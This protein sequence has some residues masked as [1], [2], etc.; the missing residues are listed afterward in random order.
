MIGTPEYMSPEQVEGKEVDQRSDIYSLGVILYEMVTGQVPFEGDTPFAIGVRHKSEIPRDPKELNAQIP[1][2]LSN[3]I[4][5]CLEKDKEKRYQS[6]GEV[7]S[8]LASI[9]KG[10]P[11]TEKIIPEKKPI[12]SREITVT[13]GIKKLFIPA[14]VVVA[15]IIIAILIWQPWS[16]REAIPGPSDKPSLAVMYFENNTGDK[17][18]DH[19][20]KALSELLIADLS[21]SKF[22]R[23]LSGDRLFDILEEMNLLEEDSYSSK[24]LENVAARGGVENILRGGYSKAGDVLRINTMLQKI[25]TGELLSS[26]KVEG[27]GEEGMFSMVDELTRKIKEDFKLSEEQIASDKDKEV[28]KITT[29]FPEAYKYY[30]EGRKYT[31][32]GDYRQSISF[33]ERAVA[34][35]PEFAMAYRSMAACYSNLGR[36][37]EAKKYWQKALELSDRLSEKEQLIIHGDFFY[38]VEI[39]YDRAIEFYNK[40]LSLYPDNII[41]N[42]NLGNIYFRLE[43]WDKAK[44]RYEKAM[45]IA[46][47][48]ANPNVI[49]AL[50]Y[51]SQGL[52]GE[53]NKVLEDYINNVSDSSYIRRFLAV[54]SFC[55]EKYDRA[56]AEVD[57]AFLLDPTSYFNSWVKGDIELYREN[58]FE[59]EREY[60]KLLESEDESVQ[61]CGRDRM[62]CL[63]LSEGKFKE[64]ENQLK[65]GIELTEKFGEKGWEWQFHLKLAYIFQKTG[66]PEK[67]LRECNDA[68]NIAAEEVQ[69]IWDKPY[70]LYFKGLAYL[71]MKSISEARRVAD[72]LKDLINKG[73]NRKLI[74]LHHNLMGLIDIEKENFSQA[75]ENFQKSLA[76]YRCQFIEYPIFLSNDHAL[77]MDPLARAYY[78]TGNTE[79]AREEYEKIISL[80]AGRIYYGDIYA[81]SFYML[82]KIHEQQGNKAKAIEHYEKFLD[83]WK[84]ADSGIAELEDAEKKLAKLKKQT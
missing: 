64:S 73:M 67:A 52:Y 4:M 39:A 12:T 80:S 72:E 65:Q 22:L 57:K 45:Q 18:L 13:F 55:Q 61:I 42:T 70:I 11:T 35:D 23:V 56:L 28:G 69:R 33:M 49:L 1:E 75:I 9:K 66:N 27:K 14:L 62:G 54:N 48:A 25:S 2:D 74:R 84:D 16:Q 50:L 79:K 20:R 8:E 31:I 37:A 76:L 60:Q 3:V 83:L 82:G 53:A 58:F 6:A 81:K 15:L 41:G 77:F 10:I 29:S 34:I 51:M 26:E 21:Q 78:I 38:K 36:Y 32:R 5:R 68:W 30:S 40:L 19:W 7:R 47:E 71:G 43:Q 59:A 24:D 63:C 17:N 44:E 46:P